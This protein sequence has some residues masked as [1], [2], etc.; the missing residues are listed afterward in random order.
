[1]YERSTAS[2]HLVTWTE[3]GQLAEL[4]MELVPD[5]GVP[6]HVSLPDDANVPVEADVAAQVRDVHR[7]LEF[8][9]DHDEDADLDAFESVDDVQDHYD[10]LVASDENE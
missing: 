7:M 9:D 10:D 1:M 4:A 8:I 5:T 6:A 3:S 2:G